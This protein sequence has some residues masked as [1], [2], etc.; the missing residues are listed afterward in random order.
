VDALQHKIVI[1]D[2]VC[3][4][5]NG[6]SQFII[7]RGPDNQIKLANI[8]S[9]I[10]KQLLQHFGYDANDVTTMLYIEEGRCWDKSD[11]FFKVIGQLNTPLKYLVIFKIIPK[12]IRDWLYDR[13]ALN[14]YRLFGKYLSC[15]IPSEDDKARFLTD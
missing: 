4:L 12:V 13:I 3:K 1:F 9:D 15:P 5:C 2:G 6:W 8:Q 11:A 10:G 7:K 14:R